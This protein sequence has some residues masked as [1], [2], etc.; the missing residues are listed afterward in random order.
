MDHACHKTAEE[1]MRE[2]NVLNESKTVRNSIPISDN[3][4]YL[5]WI[6][7][8][9]SKRPWLS[10]TGGGAC[11]KIYLWFVSSCSVILKKIL[12]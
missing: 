9:L 11:G 4:I 2:K 8:R 5:R 10:S 1:E 3:E 6:S 12:S 7:W